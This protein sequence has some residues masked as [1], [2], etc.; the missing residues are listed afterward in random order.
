MLRCGIRARKNLVNWWPALTV[1]G[2]IAC[3]EKSAAFASWIFKREMSRVAA[4]YRWLVATGCHSLP[5]DSR[6]RGRGRFRQGVSTSW[7]AAGVQFSHSDQVY[8]A[9]VSSNCCGSFLG[10]TLR[11]LETK[12]SRCRTV[13]LPRS[14]PA[15][16][17]PPEID[18]F[19]D[20]HLRGKM[21]LT[22][23][24]MVQWNGKPITTRWTG[25]TRIERGDLHYTTG[26]ES[27]NKRSW[28]TVSVTRKASSIE[29]MAPPADA[30]AWFITITDER[31]ATISSEIQIRAMSP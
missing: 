2:P 6:G 18:I 20:Q 5:L 3:I 26:S 29:V 14:H 19:I 23:L 15:G 17:A 8:V 25:S 24:G 12:D 9:T 13:N 22:E 11:P 1:E 27:T 31:Q 21:P 30:T 28:Q 10:P 7:S 4:D 16:W